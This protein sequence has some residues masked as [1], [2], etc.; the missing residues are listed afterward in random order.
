MKLLRRWTLVAIVLTLPYLVALVAGIAWLYER[1][2]LIWWAALTGVMMLAG[3]FILH[4][5]KLSQ[6]RDSI[7]SPPAAMSPLDET[8]WKQVEAL[9]AQLRQKPP[10]LDDPQSYWNMLEQV[11]DTVAR[12][13]HPQSVQPL[14]E[15]PVPY[16]LKVIELVA[17]D[18]RKASSENIPGAH[19]LTVND[20]NKLKDLAATGG[21]LYGPAYAIY[22]AVRLGVN[23]YSALLNELSGRVAG[24]LLD[25][26][27]DE[28]RDWLLNAFILRSGHYAI[29]MYSGKL[30]LD[31][32][33]F[34]E[35]Q[36]SRT[37]ADAETASRQSEHAAAEPLRVLVLGQVKA[38]KS[39]L[40]NA[41][42]G[43][44]RAAVDVVPRTRHIEPYV[45]ERDGLQQAIILD[46]AGY[47]DA[48][49]GRDLFAEMSQ[50]VLQSDLALLVCSANTAARAPDRRLLD[51][52]R[53]F[54]QRQPDRRMPPLVVVVT[55]I[56]MLRPLGEWSPPYNLE[57]PASPKAQN[58]LAALTAVATDLG[59]NLDQVI[60]V[61]L[62]PGRTYNIEESLIPA[63]LHSLPD[64]EQAKCLRCLRD[65]HDA[66]YWRRL[67][68]QAANAG[69]ILV[70]A[71]IHLA[72]K[73]MPK[74]P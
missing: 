45:L 4:R 17:Q 27:V 34:P 41:V 18:L 54:Y 44:T 15:V 74:L 62:Y 35:Y 56:D 30:V 14:W 58:I 26:S 50:E 65:F 38:G 57:H 63:M 47:D 31:E 43:Q 40:I 60:P 5:V 32:T 9:S 71:G 7:T 55:H 49:S 20:L 21:R 24:T 3:R 42:F 39:S 59:V 68:Q 64:A 6:A 73:A 16:L 37:K 23:P 69:R 48:E 25:Q 36:T 67:W 19:I 53:A 72:N 10:P 13:Y 70:K 2:W 29:D 61:C 66:E 28:G 8:A 1:G 12:H 33:S 22:R 52:L 51:D 11:F 46:T